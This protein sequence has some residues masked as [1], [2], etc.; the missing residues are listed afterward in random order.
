MN[1]L[2]VEQEHHA[3][4]GVAQT[5]GALRDGLEDR[6][7]VGRRLADHL[8]DVAGRRLL[9]ERFSQVTVAGLEFL[10]QPHVLDRN[11]GL[12]GK[13][14]EQS[15]LPVQVGPGLGTPDGDRP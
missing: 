7:G 1:Q 13:G 10:E 3:V 2:A 6:L 11:H 15:D 4:F 12:V 14:L 8:Q 5:Q 9:L